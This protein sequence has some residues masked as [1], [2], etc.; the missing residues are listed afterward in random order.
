MLV[1]RALMLRA[2]VL[3]AL[4]LRLLVLHLLMVAQQRFSRPYLPIMNYLCK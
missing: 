1:L 2:L 3:R 4:V